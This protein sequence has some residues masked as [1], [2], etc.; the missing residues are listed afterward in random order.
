M[1]QYRIGCLVDTYQGESGPPGRQEEMFHVWESPAIRGGRL[2]LLAV[3]IVRS[4]TLPAFHKSSFHLAS[5]QDVDKFS[6]GIRIK[7][8]QNWVHTCHVA[9]E[10]AEFLALFVTFRVETAARIFVHLALRGAPSKS[11]WG[12]GD[13][14]S[15]L[16]LLYFLCPELCPGIHVEH[17]VPSSFSAH[18]RG[19]KD[20]SY[21][22]ALP[23]AACSKSAADDWHLK[24]AMMAAR[25]V[26]RFI[27]KCE[28]L[29]KELNWRRVSWK[30]NNLIW[31]FLW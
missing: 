25:H 26:V 18:S 12:L 23:S 2:K 29:L 30:W 31:R 13:Q 3:L 7:A 19:T 15:C 24:S 27:C 9:L 4:T 10:F 17:A 22:W 1:N 11:V 20:G 16:A 28:G 14:W 5:C 21:G 6:L 8:L